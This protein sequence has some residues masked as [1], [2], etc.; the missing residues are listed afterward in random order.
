[1][2]QIV[3]CVPNFSTSDPGTVELIINE[4]KKTLE[5]FLLDYTFDDYYNRLVVSFVGNKVL[6]DTYLAKKWE[7]EEGEP[8]NLDKINEFVKDISLLIDR[9]IYV[10]KKK[11]DAGYR[12]IFIPNSV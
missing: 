11:K 8:Y 3:E 5:A 7:L 10:A 9:L 1:M 6:P 2:N 4:I 12:V